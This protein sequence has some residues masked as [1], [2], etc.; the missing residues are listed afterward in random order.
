MQKEKE[1][2]GKDECSVVSPPHSYSV[3]MQQ[4]RAEP[5]YHCCWRLTWSH[6]HKGTLLD[7]LT[8][9]TLIIPRSQRRWNSALGDA[10]GWQ[11]LS[12]SAVPSSVLFFSSSACLCW[13]CHST[14]RLSSFISHTLLCRCEMASVFADWET[15]Q[16][17]L[18]VCR[19][20]TFLSSPCLSLF[21]LHVSGDRSKSRTYLHVGAEPDLDA[22]PLY[23]NNRAELI[24][25][26]LIMSSC[27]SVVWRVSVWVVIVCDSFGMMMSW[28]E[29]LLSAALPELKC[30]QL[31]IGAAMQV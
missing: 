22:L 3:Q 13:D 5:A 27:D 26:I 1:G 4:S 16:T 29:Y 17:F 14:A 24:R 31:I 8:S 7:S 21:S 23:L 10:T 18:S 15:F 11:P 2:G 19:A 25:Y 20:H 30:V 6:T 9:H 12:K 28:F